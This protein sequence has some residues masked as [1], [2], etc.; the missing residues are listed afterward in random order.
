MNKIQ[1]LIND[2]TITDNDVQEYISSNK[3]QVEQYVIASTSGLVEE[4]MVFHADEDGDITSYSE[5]TCIAARYGDD[6]WTDA[7]AAVN[8]LNTDEYK[9]IHVRTIDTERNVHNL[10][11]RIKVADNI[12]I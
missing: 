7:F 4:T 9:Y 5:L 2:G 6:N 10:F 1:A 12:V 11:K 8:R 3:E